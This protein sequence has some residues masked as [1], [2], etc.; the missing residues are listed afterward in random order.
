MKF[1]FL[2]GGW[3]AFAFLGLWS[4]SWGE[5]TFAQQGTSRRYQISSPSSDV[6]WVLDTN[7]GDCIRLSYRSGEIRLSGTFSPRQV[8]LS[9]EEKKEFYP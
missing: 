8:F 9:P 6:A 2:W 1:I 7:T 4:L 5:K 3:V